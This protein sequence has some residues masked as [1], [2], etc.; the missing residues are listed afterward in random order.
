MGY[1]IISY[2]VKEVKNK[3]KGVFKMTEKMRKLRDTFTTSYLEGLDD[4]NEKEMLLAD[5]G[6]NKLIDEVTTLVSK[7]KAVDHKT[8]ETIRYVNSFFNRTIYLE[9]G[10][11]AKDLNVES[12]DSRPMISEAQVE[13]MVED[14]E[15]TWEQAEK[16]YEIVNVNNYMHH[17]RNKNGSF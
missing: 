16:Q 11:I 6:F 14:G 5:K 9:D 4:T 8:V 17:G 13:I 1:A 15:I 2:R 7:Y 12:D 3:F 10:S